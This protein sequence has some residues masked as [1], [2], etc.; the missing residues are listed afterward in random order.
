MAEIFDIQMCE[1]Q[2]RFEIHEAQET[3]SNI[4]RYNG[5]YSEN[6]IHVMSQILKSADTFIDAGANIGWHTL[7]GSKF[8]GPQGRVLAFEPEP[9]NFSLLEKNIAANQLTNVT[10]LQQA[11]GFEVKSEMLHLSSF[12]FGDHI[13]GMDTKNQA[14]RESIPVE[15]TSLDA[16]FQRE[17]LD[18]SKVSLLKMDIQGSEPDVLLGMRQVLKTHR[19]S[20]LLEFSPKHIYVVGSSQFDVFAFV[21]KYRYQPF[22]LRMEKDLAKEEILKPLSV[23]DLLG[24]SRALMNYETD[25]GADLL[26]LPM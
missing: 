21:D 23:E 11:L 20:I 26:L 14:E 8:V 22:L 15:V 4:V 24:L 1:Q 19:P 12:N 7:F 17:N 16:F 18:F 2:L 25:Q 13:V 9:R 3:V 5:A 10:A 6:D